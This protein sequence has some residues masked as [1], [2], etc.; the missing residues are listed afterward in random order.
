MEDEVK[1]LIGCCNADVNAVEVVSNFVQVAIILLQI[2]QN[3]DTP[4]HY[5]ARCNHLT[6]AEKL[7]EHE[8]EIN[9]VNIVRYFCYTFNVVTH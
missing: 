2:I 4:L 9:A 3:Q 8:A 1:K 6:I 5:A 7:I